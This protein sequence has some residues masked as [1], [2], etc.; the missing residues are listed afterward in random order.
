MISIII[1]VSI[2]TVG[3][4][5]ATFERRFQVKLHFV[6]LSDVVGTTLVIIGLIWEKMADLELLLALV[7]LVIWS[8][9]LTHMLMKAYL[10]K[11]GKR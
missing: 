7:F 4:I 2:M 10:S 11:V 5:R 9:Y 8:P 6:G 3:M 1:G